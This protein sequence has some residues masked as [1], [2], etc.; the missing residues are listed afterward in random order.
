[1]ITSQ[2][3]HLRVAI[4]AMRDTRELYG[5]GS[6]AGNSMMEFDGGGTL[7]I[8]TNWGTPAE[9]GQERCRADNS[10]LASIEDD[11][12]VIADPDPDH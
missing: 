7:K 12:E 1:M 5:I 6:A 3:E 10:R 9:A 4:E 11:E 2:R 8:T